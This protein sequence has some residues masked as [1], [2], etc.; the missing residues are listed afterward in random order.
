MSSSAL[1]RVQVSSSDKKGVF[2]DGQQARIGIFFVAAFV[3]I[4]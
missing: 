3:V 2:P 4:T 1:E